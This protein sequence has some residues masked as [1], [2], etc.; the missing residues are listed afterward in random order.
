MAGYV[1]PNDLNSAALLRARVH[2]ALTGLDGAGIVICVIDYGFDLLHPTLRTAGGETRFAALI[3]QNGARLERA[4]INAL[5]RVA[6][7]SGDRRAIDRVYDPHAHYF[8]RDGVQ[9][10]AHGSW[11][12]SIAAGSRTAAFSGVAPKATLIAVQLALPDSA[13]REE[14]GAGRPTWLAAATA[15]PAALAGWKGWRAYEDSTAIVAALEESLALACALR[16]DG[17]VF[18]LSIGAWAGGHDG[19]SAVNRASSPYGFPSGPHTG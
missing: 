19:G 12:A 6:E 18:N 9:G 16:P 10:G 13:W 14:D 7:T 8:G 15:G 17:I 2:P 4:E 1:T 5:L 3:D 11:V